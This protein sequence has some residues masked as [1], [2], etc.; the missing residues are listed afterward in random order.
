MDKNFNLMGKKVNPS[1]FHMRVLET[2][3]SLCLWRTKEEWGQRTSP[4][5]LQRARMGQVEDRQKNVGGR[6]MGEQ[7]S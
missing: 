1:V 6:A 7:D 5:L 4:R 2:E 3:L